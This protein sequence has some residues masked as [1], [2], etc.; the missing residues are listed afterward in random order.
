MKQ[1][2]KLNNVVFEVKKSKRV[3]TPVRVTRDLRDC[4]K[5][6]SSAKKEI[7][8]YWYNY[9]IDFLDDD[10]FVGRPSVMTYNSFSF[11]IAFNVYDYDWKFIG[12][13]YI[14]R[15]HNYLYLA[16]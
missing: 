12:V 6:P 1:N 15:S 10:Y 4:Y 7:F 16:R 8:D 3:L 11:T 2:I 14:T 9:F 5:N 13:A